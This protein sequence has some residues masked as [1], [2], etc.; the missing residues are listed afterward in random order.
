V[1]I[2]GVLRE[3]GA[4]G[5]IAVQTRLDEE[6]ARAPLDWLAIRNPKVRRESYT[7]STGRVFEQWGIA[8]DGDESER[9]AA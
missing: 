9:E 8:P 6:T 7:L 2:S 5:F 1:H 4:V 3:P